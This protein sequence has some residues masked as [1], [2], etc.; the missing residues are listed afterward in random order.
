MKREDANMSQDVL[1]RM[2]KAGIIPVVVIDDPSKA[3]QLG[4]TL[5][6]AGLDLIEITMRT[7]RAME[8]I[9]ALTK[10][11]PEILVGA[12]TVF[13]IPIAKRGS[14]PRSTLHSFPSSRRTDR[15]ILCEEERSLRPRSIHAIRDPKSNRR[16][17]KRLAKGRASRISL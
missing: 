6:D 17:E 15:H 3:V 14:V 5:L 4:R 11:L 12:G 8:A 9:R 10:G 16:C 13:S 1:A 7:E 2:E